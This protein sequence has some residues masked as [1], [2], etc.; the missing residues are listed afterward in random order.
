MAIFVTSDA[1]YIGINY[2]NFWF[3]SYDELIINLDKLT[4]VEN[5]QNIELSNRSKKYK[6]F[7]G[8]IFDVNLVSE[9]LNKYILEDD[10]P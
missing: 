10:L 8:D 4:Y 5:L 3:A 6:F 7:K 1:G 2:I 9:T